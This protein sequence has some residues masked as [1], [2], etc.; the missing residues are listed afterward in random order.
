MV[1]DKNACPMCHR[2]PKAK[3]RHFCS[4]EC[5]FEWEEYDRYTED[6]KERVVVLEGERSDGNVQDRT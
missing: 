5:Q 3:G 4:S 1:N 2:Q 6:L